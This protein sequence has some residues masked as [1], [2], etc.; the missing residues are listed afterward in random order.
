MQTVPK[1]ENKTN[2]G[3]IKCEGVKYR[4]TGKIKGTRAKEENERS[5]GEMKGADS[6]NGDNKKHEG[7]NKL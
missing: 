6:A 1:G 5:R 4:I 3:E 2:E 7:G